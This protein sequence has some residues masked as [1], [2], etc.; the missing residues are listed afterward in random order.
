MRWSSLEHALA[1]ADI[2]FEVNPKHWIYECK[3]EFK[4]DDKRYVWT[5]DI[6]TAFNGKLYAI[7]VQLSNMSAKSWVRKWKAWN[8]YFK[9]AFKTAQYQQWSPS[10]KIMLPNFVVV[11]K[12]KKAA[13]GFN[14]QQRE[15]T[16][17][18]SISSLI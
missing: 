4:H 1:I 14:I 10:G 18:D 6:V 9:D 8:L 16:I 5:P 2:Y 3:E 15:L 13:E 11:T 7:E 17:V 12:N